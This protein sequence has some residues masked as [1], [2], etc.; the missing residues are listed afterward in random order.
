[1]TTA[2]QIAAPLTPEQKARRIEAQDQIGQLRAELARYRP[3][4]GTRQDEVDRHLLDLRE[5]L[6]A[7]YEVLAETSTCPAYELGMAKRLRGQA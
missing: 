2:T 4:I 1:M 5:A 3:S 6:A 7:A